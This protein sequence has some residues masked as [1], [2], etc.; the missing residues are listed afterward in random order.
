M[1]GAWRLD[2]VLRAGVAVAAM[3]APLAAAQAGGFALR[4][5]SPFFQGMSFAGEAAGG[6][7]SSM[8][9]NSAAAAINGNNIEAN[10]TAIVPKSNIHVDT[11]NGGAPPGFLSNDAS[12]IGSTAALP[13]MYANYQ[14]SKDL[15][16]GVGIN[17]PFGTKTQPHNPN[18]WGGVLA[19]KTGLKTYNF[20]PTLAWRVLPGLTIGAGAQI[21]YGQGVLNFGPPAIANL[22]EFNGDGYGYGFTAGALIEPFAGT[23]IGVGYRSQMN[24]KLSGNLVTF[25]TPL[26]TNANATLTLPD[27][28]TVSLRQSVTP[29]MRLLG[30]VEYTHWSRFQNLTINNDTKNNVLNSLAITIPQNWQD[31]WLYSI[32]GEYDFA[33]NLTLRTGFA[34]E[35]SPVQDPTERNLG[36]PDNNRYWL[37]GGATWKV[38]EATAVDFAYSHLFI[39]TGAFNRTALSGTVETGSVASSTDIFSVGVKTKW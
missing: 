4:E 9:W 20:N 8:Y 10:F 34:Y 6:D 11:V 37:S 31:G 12:G 15:F 36:F 1:L 3:L 33:K 23:S 35:K 21:Q 7:I 25:G 2:S 26:M 24:Q 32:G 38:T 16:I 30:T 28:V 18:Y 5:Q 17:S 29:L 39:D 13:S 19:E 22:T 14:L 27:M